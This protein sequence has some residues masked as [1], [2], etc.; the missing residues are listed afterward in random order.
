VFTKKLMNIIIGFL[1]LSLVFNMVSASETGTGAE[2]HQR[3]QVT[4][5]AGVIDPVMESI[6]G[7]V[8]LLREFISRFILFLPRCLCT[9]PIDMV[10]LII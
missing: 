10:R 8:S 9:H 4:D 7:L 1:L 6:E 5:P 2:T 3:A